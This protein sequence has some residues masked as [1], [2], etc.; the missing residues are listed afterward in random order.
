MNDRW[1]YPII[2]MCPADMAGLGVT[3][4]DPV[5]IF[6]NHGATQAIAYPIDTAKPGQTF[7]IFGSPKGAQGNVVSDGVNELVVPVYKQSWPNIRKIANVPAAAKGISF[8]A[9]K[10]RL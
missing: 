4:G 2:E 8:K 1:P 6:N 9:L 5:E 3:Q 10:V 7:I